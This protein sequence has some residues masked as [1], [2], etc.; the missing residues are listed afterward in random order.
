MKQKIVVKVHMSCE[1]CRTKAMKVAAVESGVISVQISGEGKDQVV[2]V[3]D[4]IDSVSLTRSLRK[5]VGPATLLSVEEV[6]EPKKEE[7][8][9]AKNQSTSPSPSLCYPQPVF[10]HQIVHD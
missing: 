5:K 8:P 1:K 10:C 4:E 6:K 3:G 7:P 2:V 9:A